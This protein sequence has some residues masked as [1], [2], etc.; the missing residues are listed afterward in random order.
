MTDWYPTEP[1]ADEF[2]R[3]PKVDLHRHLEGSLRLST[4]LDLA[5]AEGIPLPEGGQLGRRVQVQ[6]GDPRT[7]ANFLEKF[8]HQRPFYTSPETIARLT[9]E[10]VVDAAMDGVRLLELRFTP[11]SLA[12]TRGY[13]IPE[14]IDWV[15]AGARRAGQDTGI[16][17]NLI[18]SVNRH[19]PLAAA[20]TVVQAAIDR[21]ERGIA[22]IDLAGD[23]AN[24]PAG[25]FLGLFRE[26]RQSGLQI[27]IHAGEWGGPEN[28]R[29]AIEVFGAA[30]VGHGVRVLED[31]R[32]VALAR[33]HSTPFEVCLTSNVQSGVVPALEQHPLAAMLAAGLNVSLNSDDPGIQC[34]RLSD[35]YRAAARVLN[36]PVDVLERLTLAAAEASFLDAERKAALV[37]ELS[38]EF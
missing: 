35:E 21:R 27:C 36:V 12:R 30:R 22:G 5:Q 28:V 6:A 32:V 26:A 31:S 33:E 25:P 2:V 11:S 14:V 10:A 15:I 18:A 16:Q 3:M 24:F 4:L 20:E 1:Q 29:E 8:K 7:V 34:I 9:N 38:R 13:P 23:E 37:E 19:D 17:T